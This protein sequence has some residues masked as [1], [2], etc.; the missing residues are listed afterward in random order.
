[1]PCKVELPSH[2]SGLV[3]DG[4]EWDH[5]YT[6]VLVLAIEKGMLAANGSVFP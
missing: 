1:M 4:N 3:V 6:T 5:I 2:T